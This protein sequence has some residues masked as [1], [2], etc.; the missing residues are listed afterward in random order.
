MSASGDEQPAAARLPRRPHSARGTRP[1]TATDS[2]RAR[3]EQ[4]KAEGDA[5]RKPTFRSRLTAA[6]VAAKASAAAEAGPDLEVRAR[7]RAIPVPPARGRRGG[8]ALAVDARPNAAPPTL[9]PAAAPKYLRRNGRWR[10][11]RAST[12]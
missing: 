12:R 2:L 11:R 4:L 10:P 1:G 5:K 9:T 7:P 3:F 8:A 6:S